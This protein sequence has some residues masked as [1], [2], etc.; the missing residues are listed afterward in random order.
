MKILYSVVHFIFYLLI[1]P[2][3]I[4]T[5]IIIEAIPISEKLKDK[6]YYI[7]IKKIFNL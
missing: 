5:L 3:I 1:S 4:L 7:A 2:I 6:F